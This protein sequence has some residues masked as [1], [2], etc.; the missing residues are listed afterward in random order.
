[1]LV[2]YMLTY[3]WHVIHVVK[4]IL[5]LYSFHLLYFTWYPM[6]KFC[7][8][9]VCPS[10]IL[11]NLSFILPSMEKTWNFCRGGVGLRKSVSQHLQRILGLWSYPLIRVWQQWT[12]S[13][14]L[15]ALERT[16]SLANYL[17]RMQ[18]LVNW[19]L[20]PVSS[21]VIYR[22]ALRRSFSMQQLLFFCLYF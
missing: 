17:S 15:C 8:I 2:V 11:L 5:L 4:T 19:W 7:E 13:S 22:A 1:M 9:V 18:R 3:K 20:R 16:I 10:R 12:F 6:S 14:L 21:T